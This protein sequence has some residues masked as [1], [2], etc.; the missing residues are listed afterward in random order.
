VVNVVGAL[1]GAILA[2]CTLPQLYQMYKTRSADDISLT[3]AVMYTSGLILTAIYLC[4]VRA[5]ASAGPIVLEC[6]LGALL[7]CAKI[8]L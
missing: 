5:W 6:L 1:G 7:V 4:F 3:W 2:I 8:A